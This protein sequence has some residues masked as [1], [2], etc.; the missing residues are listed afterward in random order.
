M[1]ITFHLNC[2]EQGG[3]ER[4]VTNLSDALVNKGHEVHIATEWIGENEF[5]PDKRVKRFVVGLKEDEEKKSRV[6][7]FFRRILFLKEYMAL[8]EEV[9]LCRFYN[10]QIPEFLSSCLRL[11]HRLQ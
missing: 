8:S 9:F 7:K 6:G 5:T 2:L 11:R 4:V 10:L 1:K 3:A